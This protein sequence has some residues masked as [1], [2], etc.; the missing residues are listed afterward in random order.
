MQHGIF[1]LENF[2]TLQKTVLNGVER[3]VIWSKDDAER[4]EYSV[5][6]NKVSNKIA[7]R[8]ETT[9]RISSLALVSLMDYPAKCRQ[10][11]I[12]HGHTMIGILVVKVS[13]Y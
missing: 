8:L 3:T 4:P 9:A 11:V 2:T 10:G 6:L 13:T 7:I 1:P 12:E 5:G